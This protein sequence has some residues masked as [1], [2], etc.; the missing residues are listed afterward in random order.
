MTLGPALIISFY[1]PPYPKVGSRRWVKFAKYLNRH[2]KEVYVLAAQMDVD[3]NSPWDDDAKEVEHL[4]TRLHFKYSAPYYKRHTPQSIGAKV[5]WHFSK[6]KHQLA[7][8]K[9]VPGNVADASEKYAPEF[10]KAAKKIIEQKN[11][12]TVIFTASPNHLAYH[13][14]TLKKE[15]PKVKFIFDLRDYWSDWMPHLDKAQYEYESNLEEQTIRN[16]DIILSPA[17]KILNTLKLRYPE[18][19][20]VMKVLPHAFDND[21]FTSITRDTAPGKA[22]GFIQLVYAGTMYD[23]MEDN[24]FLLSELLSQN[25]KVYLTFYTFTQDYKELF[26]NVNERVNYVKPLPVKEFTVKMQQEADAMLYM[27][28]T[29]NDDNNFLSSKFFDFLPLKKPI[30]YLGNEG[31]A[32][33]FITNEK[34]GFHLSKTSIHHIESLINETNKTIHQFNVS[35]YSFDAVTKQL[36]AELER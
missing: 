17:K 5:R 25:P 11:I 20:P 28:S 27:R 14:S 33:E 16:S 19:A 15:Y 10:L 18:K 7:K 36:E 13:I 22:S 9:A 23:N 1:Y 29:L 31:D 3:K 6:W 26:V 35:G 24:M 12:S 21:D 4:T 8:T 2:Q 34:I 30:V 32:L